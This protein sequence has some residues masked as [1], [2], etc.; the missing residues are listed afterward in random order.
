MSSKNSTLFFRVHE[1]S[2]GAVENLGE[3]S[4]ISGKKISYQ[5]KKLN[6]RCA[7]RNEPQIIVYCSEE[8]VMFWT[9]ILNENYYS[10]IH[11][12]YSCIHSQNFIT[13]NSF[14]SKLCSILWDAKIH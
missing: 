9:Q 5:I 13:P 3:I 6:T 14:M 11:F 12:F 4:G 10:N 1:R 7:I 2:Y 8:F